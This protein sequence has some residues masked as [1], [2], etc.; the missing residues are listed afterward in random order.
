MLQDVPDL[1]VKHL[2]AVVAVA[3]FGSFI[4]ASA[5]LRV[6]QPGLSRII[7]QVEKLLGVALFARGTRSVTPTPA[8]QEFI[9]IAERL[10]GEIRQQTQRVRSLDGQ[11]RGEIVIASLMSISH[12][13]L[14]TVLVA[15]RKQ[16]PK[17]HIQIRDGFGDRVRED[18]RRGIADFGIGNITGLDE[19]VVVESAM[20]EPCWLAMPRG[21]RLARNAS[22]RFKDLADESMISM[23]PDV[24]LRRTVDMMASAQG[25]LLNYTLITNQYTSLFDFVRSGLGLAIVPVSSLQRP[26]DASIIARPMRPSIARQIGILHLAERPLSPVSQAFLEIFRPAFVTAIRDSSWAKARRRMTV[27][28]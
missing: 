21:H 7:Q 28:A 15:Y 11:M 18:V 12:H 26:A 2:R 25:L 3:H 27:K 1:S 4:A 5:Y 10:I 13:V 16:Y 19:A 6:S 22:V 9:P 24:G 20:L 17:V 23:P 14:P 8:G